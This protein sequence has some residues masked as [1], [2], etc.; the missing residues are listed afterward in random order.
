LAKGIVEEGGLIDA[1]KAEIEEV[2]SLTGHYA[3]LREEMEGAVAAA[4]A[5]ANSIN[6]NIEAEARRNHVS[7]NFFNSEGYGSFGGGGDYG[8]SGGGSG[9]G[10]GGG[11]LVGGQIN[12][13]NAQIYDYAGDNNGERQYFR[14]DPVYDV[15]QESGDW[16]QVRHHNLASGVTGWFRKD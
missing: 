9:S 1:L 10:G 7:S 13:G 14:N 15:L 3:N 8:G 5:L 16:V 6:R 12:A 11:S 4:E 2:K